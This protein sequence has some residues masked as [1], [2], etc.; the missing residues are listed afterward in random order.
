MKW[1]F[2]I[3]QKTTIAFALGTAFLFVFV[4]NIMDRRQVEKLGV[5]FSSIYEDRLLV[6]SYIFRIAD[7]LHHKKTVMDGC[8]LP[9]S[10]NQELQILQDNKH[11]YQLVEEY[12]KT[13][14]TVRES[15]IFQQLQLNLETI[16]QREA[17][18]FRH[19]N[20]GEKINNLKNTLQ[21]DY[22]AATRQLHLL[23]A[24]QLA[25]A[26]NMHHQSQ[27]MIFGSALLTELEFALIII[28]GLAMQIL[29]VMVSRKPGFPTQPSLN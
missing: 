24:I 10:K 6:E 21:A 7:L 18:M 28:A 17:D 11:I 12:G 14:L 26:K 8:G 15:A 22:V 20:D 1:T 4:K 25:E 2:S 23:S 9:Q 16:K 29:L 13:K 19:A 27:Q 3:R 5:S